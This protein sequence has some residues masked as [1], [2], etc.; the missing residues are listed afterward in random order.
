M[1]P[2][3]ECDG[4]KLYHGS[5]ADVLPAL[6]IGGWADLVMADPPYGETS[7]AWDTWPA[8]WPGHILPYVK[9][10]G[11]LWCF[12]SLRMFLGRRDEFGNGGWRM[13]HE[14]VWEKHNG[15]GFHVDRFRRV[16]ELAVHFYPTASPWKQVFKSPQFTMDAQKRVVR[17]KEKPAQWHGKTGSTTYVSVDGGP[18]RMRSVLQVRSCHGRALNETEKPAGILRPLVSYGCPPGGRLLVPFVGSGSD[19]AIA[20]ELG[21]Q[22]IGC[23]LREDQCEVAA[24]RLRQGQLLAGGVS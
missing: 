9:S 23:E 11:S 4:I 24:N 2:Y 5:Y 15:S 14:V 21:L 6:A 7:L 8:G 13:S 12:G 18:R 10:T 17:K 22:A 19:L 16:H 20:R 1:K 3:F